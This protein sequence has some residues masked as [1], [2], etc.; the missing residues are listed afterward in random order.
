M[1]ITPS[2]DAAM[3]YFGTNALHFSE[4]FYG[5][6]LLVDGAAQVLGELQ[7]PVFQQDHSYIWLGKV[8]KE[9]CIADIVC[10]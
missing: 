2:V 10:W 9:G 5:I 4:Q 7:L 8:Q 6:I 3:F 1:K